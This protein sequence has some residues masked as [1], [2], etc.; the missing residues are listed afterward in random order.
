VHTRNAGD[1]L[2]T[3]V[4]DP[5]HF[6][7]DPDADPACHFYV[8]PYANPNFQVDADPDPTFYFDSD[9]DPIFQIKD[10]NLGKALI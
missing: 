3:S 9:L 5:H 2:L 8:D 6:D 10:Q 7:A 1:S 4:P